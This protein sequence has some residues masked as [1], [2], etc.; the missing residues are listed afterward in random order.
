MNMKG[1]ALEHRDGKTAVLLENGRIITKKGVIETGRSIEVHDPGS[2]FSMK[3]MSLACLCA[4]IMIVSFVTYR[5]YTWTA[6]AYSTI[7]VHNGASIEY[8]LNRSGDVIAVK[9]ADEDSEE[10]A[11]ALSETSLNQKGTEAVKTYIES[12]PK[13]KEV[14]VRIFSKKADSEEELCH[15]LNELIDQK[16]YP[17]VRTETLSRKREREMNLQNSGVLP[18]PADQ[19]SSPENSFQP[20]E[21]PQP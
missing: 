11:A 6:L 3:R 15:E 19:G 1:I 5:N 4:V 7:I 14:N 17:N 20:I 9:A 18:R 10:T 12:I 8:T 13:D 16:E 2:L 21:I